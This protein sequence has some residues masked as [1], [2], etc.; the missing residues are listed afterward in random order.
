MSQYAKFAKMAVET[1]WRQGV[2]ARNYLEISTWTRQ[3]HTGSSHQ[4]SSFIG[5][6]LN[7]KPTSTRVY[8]PPDVNCFCAKNYVNLMVGLKQPTHSGVSPD[9]VIVGIGVEVTFEVVA[10]AVL[11]RKVALDFKVRVVNV[12]DLM[13]LGAFGTHPHAL[14]E[15][16]FEGMFTKDREVHQ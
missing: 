4:N 14:S 6:V 11:P 12:T 16:A 7:L 15:E 13:M 10:A 3:K 5:A 8:L 2:S 9:V 1:P